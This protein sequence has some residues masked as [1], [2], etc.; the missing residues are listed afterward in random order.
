MA[1]LTFTHAS[2]DCYIL[3]GDL[4]RETIS[5]LEKN[6]QRQSELA[7][8][9]AK[10]QGKL[11]FDLKGIASADTAGLAWLIHFLGRCQEKKL[12]LSLDN[13]PTQLHNLMQLGQVSQLFE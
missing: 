5:A 12:T 2:D 7:A 13:V 3:T 11:T 4:V 1:E 10:S 9:L 8:L 6:K